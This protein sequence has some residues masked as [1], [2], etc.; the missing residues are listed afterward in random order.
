MSDEHKLK[1][2]CNK[3]PA[4]YILEHLRAAAAARVGSGS[5]GMGEGGRDGVMANEGR[6]MFA[7]MNKSNNDSFEDKLYCRCIYCAMICRLSSE[8]FSKVIA[9]MRL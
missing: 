9:R 1:E 6:R 3:L 5:L 4:L 7:M 2:F 8:N